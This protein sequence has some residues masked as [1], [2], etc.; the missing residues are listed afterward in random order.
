MLTAKAIKIFADYC[1]SDFAALLQRR[2]K[3]V[4]EGAGKEDISPL[5][6]RITNWHFFKEN[7]KLRPKIIFYGNIIPLRVT[8]TSEI[9][10]K[11]R[12]EQFLQLN[13]PG[14]QAVL[15]GRILHHVQDMSTP[16][17]AV[18]VYHGP[19]LKD[20]FENYSTANIKAELQSLAI[21]RAE[22]DAL[23]AGNKSDI[24]AIYTNAGHKTLRQ[25]Y[26][27]PCSRFEIRGEGNEIKEIGW[28]LFWR[29]SGAEGDGC[30]QKP[31]SKIPGFGCYGPLAEQ[32]GKSW[33]ELSGKSYRIDP[34]VYRQLHSWVLREQV[35]DSLRTLIFI[36][37]RC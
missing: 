16:A 37:S 31:F 21:T 8:P 29:R 12:I 34:E 26:D 25:L 35:I 33:L 20:S 24:M 19:L 17:H 1:R 6:T 5:Y 2:T 10:L 7:H 22:Y 27:N 36:E 32:F 13:S 11:G 23:C 30:A 15:L 14:R 4:E 28:D 18:P 9:I 3:E